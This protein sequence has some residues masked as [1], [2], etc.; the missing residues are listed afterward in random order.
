[1]MTITFVFWLLVALFAIVGA[2][3]GWAKELLVTFAVIVGLFLITVLERFVPFMR[4]TLTGTGR[5]WMQTLIIMVLVFF[6]YQ[7]PQLARLA[8]SGRFVRE[9]L[10]DTLLGLFLGALNGFLIFGSVWYYMHEAGYP[11]DYIAAPQSG[12]ALGDAAL[13]LIPLLAPHWM[14]P[15]MVYFAVALAFV[16]VLVVFI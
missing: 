16:F 15:P 12:T 14:G 6:A 4:D 10:Q 3:R 5:F 11:F 2:M 9:H 8:A 1:M 13:K 7:T